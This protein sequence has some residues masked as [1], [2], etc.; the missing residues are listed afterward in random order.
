MLVALLSVA[1]AAPAGAHLRPHLSLARSEPPMVRG[2][3]FHQRERVKVVVIQSWGAKLVKRTRANRA[4]RFRVSFPNANPPCGN[5]RVT[6]TGSRGSRAA[7]IGMKFP[8]CVI[9]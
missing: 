9:R 2:G 6:A 7:L 5:Y 4:G 3:G 8:A 1:L